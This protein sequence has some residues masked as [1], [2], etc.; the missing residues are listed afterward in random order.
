MKDLC[1]GTTF[2][3]ISFFV[4]CYD[5]SI[6]E[7]DPFD[8]TVWSGALMMEFFEQH[9]I[10]ECDLTSDIIL[11]INHYIE[12][13]NNLSVPAYIFDYLDSDVV[14]E[15]RATEAKSYIM[16]TLLPCQMGAEAC[17]LDFVKDSID[18][19]FSRGDTWTGFFFDLY[20]F[21]AMLSFK[22]VNGYEL[23]L[24]ADE[25]EV[26]ERLELSDCH[27]PGIYAF[28]CNASGYIKIGMSSKGVSGRVRTQLSS[29]PLGGEFLYAVQCE[30]PSLDESVAH[31]FFNSCRV[32]PR[33]EWFKCHPNVIIDYMKKVKVNA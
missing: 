2:D 20:R 24:D 8:E 10:A 12:A 23:P 11:K 21:A 6:G 4:E 19:G 31:N 17:A 16:E 9:P 13:S 33:K 3:D 18:S 29:L 28:K 22:A 7:C 30:Q 25:E 32:S 1:E 27:W 14:I 15:E 26:C 5:L